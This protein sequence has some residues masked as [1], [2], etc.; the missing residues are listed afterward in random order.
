VKNTLLITKEKMKFISLKE[1]NNGRGD[2]PRAG[3]TIISGENINPYKPI[4]KI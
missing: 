3:M 2:I 1:I 4:Y